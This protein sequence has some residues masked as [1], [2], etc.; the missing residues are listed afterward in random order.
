MTQESSVFKVPH[1]L[2][3]IFSLIIIAAL[4]T[5]FVPGGK[6]QRIEKQVQMG[7][8]T[9]TR[10]VVVPG[11]YAQ[12]PAVPQSPWTVLK[13]IM[14]GMRHHS[15]VD[16]IF[17][18]LLIGGAFGVVT[19]TRAVEASLS[20]LV[21]FLGSNEKAVIPVVMLVFSLGGAS[22]G[23]CEETIPFVAM[24]VPLALKLGYDSITGVAMVY[25]AAMIGFATAFLNPFT[26]GIAQ[27]IAELKP[28]SG[29]GFRFVLWLFFT[30]VTIAWVMRYAAR[31][32]AD[33]ESSPVFDLDEKRRHEVL[34]ATETEKLTGGR[35]MVLLTIALGFS[36]IIYGAIKLGWYIDEMAAMFIAIGIIS[37][38]VVRMAPSDIASAF[39]KGSSEICGAA[40]MVG[41][42]RTVLILLE[43]G[44]VMDT[45]LNSVS[46]FVGGFSAM[47]SVQLMYVF[48]SLTNFF[49]PS[50]S[51]QAALTMP[52]MVPLADLLGI[53]RQ[54]AVLAYQFG[55][56]FNNVIIPTSAVTIAALGIAG[57][58]W[59]RW[60]RWVAPL[61]GVYYIL[62]AIALAGAA[63]YGWTG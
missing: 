53:T 4:V 49:V 46:G 21:K 15:A 52:I 31:I 36:A 12:A 58:P 22:F 9:E 51:G 55:D 16:I 39:I 48:Q 38:L 24:A 61:I 8:V 40:I 33:P 28:F 1:T 29:I 42:A 41:F 20:G 17:F 18:I 19:E 26:V 56:G 25:L 6:F 13:A 34:Q 32:K 43:D 57:V 7:P 30:A 5:Y 45:I 47:I 59:E 23:M 2:V 35:I 10:E 3:I 27:G 63:A 11:S 60:A 44:G 37:G 62:G 14:K 54:T 50:G